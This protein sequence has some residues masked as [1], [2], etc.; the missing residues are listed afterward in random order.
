[1]PQTVFQAGSPITSRFTLG[2]VPDGSTAVTVSVQRPDG[3]AITVPAPSGWVN[4]SQKTIQ[5]YATDDGAAGSPTNSAAGDWLV[6]WTATGVGASVAPKVYNV[7]PL[8]GTGT[9]PAW[10]PFLS[11]VADFI[12]ALT[13]DTTI[14][15]SQTYLGTFTGNTSPTDEQAQRHVDAAVALVGAGFSVLADAGLRRMARS[16]AAMRAAATIARAFSREPSYADL[17]TALERQAAADL[18]VLVEAVEN[19][20]STTLSSAPVLIAPEPVAH[21]DWLL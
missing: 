9:R 7:A 8:P 6:V 5:F 12:P 19:A 21:G 11:D 3:T 17:A 15:G 20:D 2:V 14:P 13:V 18:K 1:M 10:S 4:T 16:V